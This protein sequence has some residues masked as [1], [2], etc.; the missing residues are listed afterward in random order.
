MNNKITT[1]CQEARVLLIV[2][3]LFLTG[4]CLSNIFFNVYLW[5]LSQNLT[6]AAIFN[7]FHFLAVPVVFFLGSLIIR[8]VGTINCLRIG[9]LI[10]ACFFLL[11]LLLGQQVSTFAPLFGVLMGIGQ[12]L[13]FLGYNVSTFDWTTNKNRDKFS[14]FNGATS[15]LAGIIAPLVGGVL[16]SLLQGEMGYFIVFSMSLVCF[17]CSTFFTKTLVSEKDRYHCNFSQARKLI[18][19]KWKLVS[20]SMVLRGLREGVMTF[21]LF[22]IF[23]EITRNELQLGIYNLVLSIFTMLSY[24][25]MGVY[26]KKSWRSYSMELGA[27][28]LVAATTIILF[29]RDELSLWLFGIANS[30]F[31]PLIFVPLTA[32]SY[33]VIRNNPQTANHRIEFLTFR[34]IPLNLGRVI[35]VLLLLICLKNEISAIW[36]LWALGLTQLPIGRVLKSV[37]EKV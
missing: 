4:T 37:S 12:G 9:L 13:Y 8:F 29:R 18:D 25:L 20:W 15:A 27:M 16:I 26:G 5:K 7:L 11:V 23:Y 22:L 10:H 19:S 32:I 14:G 2:H 34:E 17:M 31:Y 36:L 21:L 33:N 1:L 28:N 35:G 30:V 6:T 24:Y 3:F